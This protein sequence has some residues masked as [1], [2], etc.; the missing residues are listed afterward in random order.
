M[1]PMSSLS[2][3]MQAAICARGHVITSNVS[4]RSEVPNRCP[5]CRADVLRTCPGC[6]YRLQGY[7]LIPGVLHGSYARP[8]FCDR[9]GAAFPWIGRQE[10]LY[11]LE[12]IMEREPGLDEATK[13]WLREQMRA[14]SQIDAMDEKA[15]REA[16]GR[17]KDHAAPCG[18][19]PRRGPS[20]TRSSP[21]P[22]RRS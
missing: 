20:S 19:A 7:E 14:L 4:G 5:Q 15:Q 11:E 2:S 16:W 17:I 18:I 8:S 1:G 12:N 22:S 10:R 9:C 3:F 13:L 6:E 21:R